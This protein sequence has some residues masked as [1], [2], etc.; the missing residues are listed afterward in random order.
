MI[1]SQVKEIENWIR[2]VRRDFHINQN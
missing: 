1:R 2:E